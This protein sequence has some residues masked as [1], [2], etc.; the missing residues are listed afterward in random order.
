MSDLSARVLVY[1]FVLSPCSSSFLSF[2]VSVL[3]LFSLIDRC[4]LIA[5]PPSTATLV[6]FGIRI[7]GHTKSDMLS[8]KLHLPSLPTCYIV[9]S[10]RLSTPLHHPLRL[11]VILTHRLA[12]LTLWHVILIHLFMASTQTFIIAVVLVPYLSF[13][14]T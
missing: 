5:S 10:L 7:L 12:S 14:L 1:F 9:V 8:Y 6:R 3:W 13:S 2:S 11:S 4:L